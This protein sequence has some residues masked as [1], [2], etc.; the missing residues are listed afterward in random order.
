MDLVEGH[1]C[2]LEFLQ[3]NTGVNIWNLGTGRGFSV[4]EVL[5]AFEIASGRSIP[6][7]IVSRRA[8]DVAVC[9]A[10]PTK[11]E[12]ELGWKARRG[13]AEMM[14]DAWRWQSLN[15]LGFSD[16]YIKHPPRSRV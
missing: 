13:L 5:R 10:N 12:R 3:S 4:R 7:R 11:A 6:Y 14:R 2:A 9:Y 15:P 16:S 1:L 8:G